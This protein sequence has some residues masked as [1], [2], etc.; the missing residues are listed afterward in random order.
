MLETIKMPLNL[1]NLTDHLPKPA[2]ELENRPKTKQISNN[3]NRSYSK[4]SRIEKLAKTKYKNNFSKAIKSENELPMRLRK[5]R[6]NSRNMFKRKA[7]TR[8]SLSRKKTQTQTSSKC[9][10]G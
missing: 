8:E 1:M 9:N 6:E 5:S 3:K 4:L 7:Y 2:Y 10:F